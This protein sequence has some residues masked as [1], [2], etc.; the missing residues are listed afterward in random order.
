M[1]SHFGACTIKEH[2]T[3]VEPR[4]IEDSPGWLGW[5]HMSHIRCM[6]HLRHI[7]TRKGGGPEDSRRQSR[8]VGDGLT[9]L[10][11]CVPPKEHIYTKGGPG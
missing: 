7:Y 9:C 4:M 3:K 2:I 11:W 5:S 10:I 8:M 1:S 6:Y